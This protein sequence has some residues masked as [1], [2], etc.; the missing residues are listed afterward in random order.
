M[1]GSGQKI[2]W[3]RSPLVFFPRVPRITLAAYDL[4]RSPPSE[5]LE[6]ANPKRKKKLSVWQIVSNQRFVKLS[7]CLYIH[8]YKH[9][10]TSSARL[11]SV[12]WSITF[13][14][15]A[16]HNERVSKY[17]CTIRFTKST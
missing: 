10:I 17:D 9:L 15:A 14:T 16:P 1:V 8:S 5:S 13:K 6:Q 11:T 3:A 2:S 12:F 4:T 7:K